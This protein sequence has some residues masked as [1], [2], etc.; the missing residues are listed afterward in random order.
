MNTKKFNIPTLFVIFGA[1][2]D[3]AQKKIFPALFDLYSK[4]LLPDQFYIVSFF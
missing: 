2:G 1:T 3:L 4:D